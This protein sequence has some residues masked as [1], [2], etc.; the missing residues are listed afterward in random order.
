MNVEGGG[1]YLRVD[2]DGAHTVSKLCVLIRSI[3]D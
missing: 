3:E 1:H 2:N